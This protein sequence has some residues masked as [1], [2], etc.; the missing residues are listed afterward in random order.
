MKYILFLFLIFFSLNIFGQEEKAKKNVV[1][2]EIGGNAFTFM[3]LNYERTLSMEKKELLQLAFRLGGSFTE[4]TFDSTITYSTP[5]EINLLIGKNRLSKGSNYL[6]LGVGYT[7][8]FS[9]SDLVATN[10]PS[11]QNHSF[12]YLMSFRVGYRFV[13]ENSVLFRFGV[14]ETVFPKTSGDSKVLFKPAIGLSFGYLF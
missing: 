4:T 1:Y 11:H 6:E 12:Y 10:I 7:P 14:L 5:T 13:M 8:F 9:S 2:L 3:S